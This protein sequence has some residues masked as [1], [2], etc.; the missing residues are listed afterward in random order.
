[1]K[2]I[3]FVSTRLDGE[4]GVSKTA[5]D[6]LTA[7]LLLGNNVTVISRD[8][9]KLP[10]EINKRAVTP[11]QWIRIL[12]YPVKDKFLSIIKPKPSIYTL[13]FEINKL[14]KRNQ[15]RN[16]KMDY[17]FVISPS[18]FFYYE[19]LDLPIQGTIIMII[20]SSPNHYYENQQR[21]SL[22]QAV[23]SMNKCDVL[24]FAS[25]NC[26]KK[27]S[28]MVSNNT[29]QMFYIPNCAREEEINKVLNYDRSILRKR[30]NI[31]DEDF[32]IV[33]VA[34]IEYRK[35]QDIL[36]NNIEK[37][38][39]LIPNLKILLIGKII[40]DMEWG[41]QVVNSI[42]K[43][44][45]KHN[46]EYLG[47]R[48]NALEYIF[49]SDLF[50]LPTRAEAMPLVVLESM[51]LK[52]PVFCSDVDGNTELIEDGISGI[53]FS[54]NNPVSFIDKFKFISDNLSSL[55]MYADRASKRYWN[56]FSREHYIQRFHDLLKNLDNKNI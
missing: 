24:I 56:Y 19:H 10:K 16:I 35:G 7:I 8:K 42:K 6:S 54:H 53:V 34:N 33:C 21:I 31:R 30:L 49:A 15:I 36:I 39:N 51:A 29:K 40:F 9:I 45:Y 48:T 14:I 52:T 12:D 43:S 38:V 4:T 17:V 46:I 22:T 41:K 27:W 50:I 11:P 23:D 25:S 1:M 2:D 3:L 44:T 37:M 20:Q 55:K 47:F 18:S 26:M 5:T 28:Y 13:L 32:T